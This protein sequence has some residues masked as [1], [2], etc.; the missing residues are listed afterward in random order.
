M[1]LI[2]ICLDK[3]IDRI[4][5]NKGGHWKIIQNPRSVYAFI[6]VC[7]S[8]RKRVN[9]AGLTVRGFGLKTQQ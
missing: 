9:G 3:L 2:L 1:G 4:R 7:D 5:P 6:D 8:A